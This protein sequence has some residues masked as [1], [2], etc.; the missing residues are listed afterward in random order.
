MLSLLCVFEFLCSQ[1]PSGMSGI[2]IGAFWFMRS[3]C[4]DISSAVL[5]TFQ[6]WHV[7]EVPLIMLS[8]TSF[9]MFI[10]G[11][12]AIFGLLVYILAAR[13][14]TRRVRNDDLNLRKVVEEHYEQQMLVRELHDCQ[15]TQQQD[16]FND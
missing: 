6:A 8:C 2:L 11:S 4:I 1:A 5:L 14:Y 9:L 10:F 16:F 13:W 12:V 3:I 15:S 7:V